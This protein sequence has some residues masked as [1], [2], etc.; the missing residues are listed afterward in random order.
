MTGA[1][2]LLNIAAEQRVAFLPTAQ[3][4][5]AAYDYLRSKVH[6]LETFDTLALAEN[7]AAGYGGFRAD[8]VRAELR[9]YQL[10]RPSDDTLMPPA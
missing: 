9:R 8:E 10:R 5:E 1:Q 6:Q 4:V 7:S 2:L 3:T